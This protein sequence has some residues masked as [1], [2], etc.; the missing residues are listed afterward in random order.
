MMD[1]SRHELTPKAKQE[2]EQRE[3]TRA[4]RNFVPEVDIAEDGDALWLWADMPGVSA[5]QVNVHLDEDSLLLEGHVSLD[6]Y[7][8]LTPA[9]TEYLV[10]D[11]V[12]RF[13][14]PDAARYDHEKITARLENGVLE[15]RLPKAAAAK[16]RK[17]PVSA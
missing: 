4:G 9:Y 1:T 8:G 14:L 5:D 6:E 16:P 3:R 11:Y 12:R 13:T 2:V 7:A 10:G 15:V 17:I